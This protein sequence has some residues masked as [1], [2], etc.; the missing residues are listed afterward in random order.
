MFTARHF[1]ALKSG[2]PQ[3]GVSVGMVIL[4]F[5]RDAL[6]PP[7]A[8]AAS[9]FGTLVLPQRFC[10]PRDDLLLGLVLVTNELGHHNQIR[11]P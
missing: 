1:F 2:V 6:R 7:A 8:A 10:A 4:M 11:V 5:W 9:S 3:G